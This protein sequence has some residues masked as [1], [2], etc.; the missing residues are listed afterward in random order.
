VRDAAS[1]LRPATAST[2]A[3][4]RLFCCAHAGG[5]AAA[6]NGW[7]Q[8]LPQRFEVIRV[9]LPGREDNLQGPPARSIDA[10]TPRLVRDVMPLLDRP[11]AF[12]G[13]SMG[14]IVMFELARALRRAARPLP[15]VLFVSGRRAPRLPLSHQP[16]YPLHDDAL[17]EQMR[18][19]GTPMP[20]L[21][22]KARWRER[23]LPTIRADLEVSDRYRYHIEPPLECSIQGFGGTADPIVKPWEW[24]AWRD[25]TSGGFKAQALSGRH[26]FDRCG[27]QALLQEIGGVLKRAASPPARLACDE[28]C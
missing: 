28:S 16:L 22:G 20:Q 17:V 26:F 24:Q 21:L 25:E 27:Q 10:I 9:Q 18:L 15:L 23:Y 5:G 7:S 14:A 13:H 1:W 11:F 8:A 19:M 2:Q 3:A 6:F 4:L 12:Y